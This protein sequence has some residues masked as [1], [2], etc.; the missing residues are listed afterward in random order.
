MIRYKEISFLYK[1][2]RS[3][4]DNNGFIEV[5]TNSM[6]ESP[7]FD[8]YVVPFSTTLKNRNTSKQLHFCSSPEFEMKRILHQCGND[9]KIYQITKAFRQDALDSIHSP[10]FNMLEW[11]KTGK[12]YLDSMSDF[13]SLFKHVSS[14]LNNSDF[15][16]Y[17]G[18]KININRNF[19][20]IRVRDIFLDKTGIDLDQVQD[21]SD[22]HK[23]A[24]RIGENHIAEG[25]S[26]DT[27][28]FILFLD[29]VE[30][31]L[32]ALDRPVILYDYP[33][34]I[35]SL[36]RNC[37]AKPWYCERF[38]CYVSGIELCN[39]YSELTDYDEHIRR[40]EEMNRLREKL[41]VDAY[42]L[43]LRLLEV[44]KAGM[45]AS[46]GVALGL[47]RLCMLMLDCQDISEIIDLDVF[48]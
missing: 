13:E 31:E 18:R 27:L 2:I 9:A 16:T 46:T 25:S 39:G 7:G 1:Q 41:G 35:A 3:W 44:I 5:R 47:D 30:R 17:Q 38:E 6:A 12:N 24:K 42:P 10:E 19:E 32:A 34:Q 37:P 36:A 15:F 23:A 29:K 21:L 11:Y 43:P 20:R 8:G 4:F 28:F 40:F 14:N 33:V 48:R 45:P 26:W 22:F